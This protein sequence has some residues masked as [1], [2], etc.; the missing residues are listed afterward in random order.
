MATASLSP[1]LDASPVVSYSTSNLPPGIMDLEGEVTEWCDSVYSQITTDRD[2]EREIKNTFQIL[3]FLEG[4]QWSDRARY[5]RS[6]PVID[7]FSRHFWE[8][9]GLL[10]DLA[11]DY[12]VYLFAKLNDFSELEQL[13]NKLCMHWALRNDFEASLYDVT[14]YGLLHSGYCK[15]SWLSSLNGG[16][17]DVNLTPIAPW[18]IGTLG[19]DNDLQQAE[20][21][22]YWKPVTLEQLTRE[23]GRERTAG[24]KPDT[25][26]SASFGGGSD[27]LRPSHIPK[28]RWKRFSSPVKQSILKHYGIEGA[29]TGAPYSQFALKREF[30][31]KDD[32]KNEGSVS[33]VV[34]P[35]D[36][37]GQPKYNWCYW[38]EPGTLIYPRG[39]VITDAGSKVMND[40][41]NPYW[42]AMHPF[43]TFRPYRVP[44]KM[45]GLPVT[46]PWMQ[47]SRVMNRI[48]GGVLDMVNSVIEPTLLA[49]KSAFPT[50]DWD[51]LDPGQS[52]GKI[53]VNNNAPWKP[54]FAKRAELPAWIFS[55]LGEID[56]EYGMSSGASAITQALGKKQVPGMES[57]DK[58]I[59]SRSFPVRVQSKALT[60]FVREIG[61]MGVSNILQFYSAAHRVAVLGAEGV[62]ASDFRPIYGQ[63]FP[64]GMK[65]EDYVRKFQ[66]II[67]PGST[68]SVE[69]DQKIQFAFQLRKTGDLSSRG[70]FRVLD[71]NF[72][73]EQNKEELLEEAKLKILV[74]AAQ[75]AV[76]GKG[77]KRR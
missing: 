72:N 44:W 68:L 11:L 46:R 29:A 71:Q 7:K 75:A 38:C 40:S 18:E 42:H 6:R 28:D 41:P 50:A 61:F 16:L 77:E 49:P 69:K 32:S 37:K 56:K 58:I 30:W 14:L 34:G 62:S 54:E 76:T 20:V 47:M 25:G 23:F 31:V 45:S 13:L 10:T 53:K 39:R 43:S 12:Q 5:A 63:S 36:E 73:F 35:T 19:A 57:L 59:N 74:A 8:S 9:V 48:Y 4:K 22:C 51:A 2:R 1:A 24:V 55:Y 64:S 27:S 17:G 15:N 21:I 67:K 52:G 60:Q 65:G 26:Y 70:L 3:D 33:F 66:F